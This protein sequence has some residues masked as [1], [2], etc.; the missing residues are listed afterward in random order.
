MDSAVALVQT[1]L[2]VNGYFTVTEFPVVERGRDVDYRMATD[3]DVLAC[4]FPGA[5]Q[6]IVG[7]G[8]GSGALSTPDEALA[9]PLGGIDM[10]VGE[11]KES[12]AEFNPAG[13]RTDVLEAAVA[14][15]GCCRPGDDARRTV[16]RLVSEGA[17][18]TGLG[19]RVRL[20]AFGA[21]PGPAA[22][23]LQIGLDRVIGYLEEYVRANWDVLRHTE[24]KE[25]ALSF[26]MIREKA[27]AGGK[28]RR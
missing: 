28:G 17:A 14:R 20:V 6:E 24:T 13:L 23:Y 8:R 26:L 18:E 21:R 12:L 11:V 22:P 25:A 19:H 5:R 9:V 4:R 7:G 1:Y 10:V 3:L 16:S 27:A 15:F 2:R